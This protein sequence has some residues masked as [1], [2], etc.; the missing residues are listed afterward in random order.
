MY[1]LRFELAQTM[2]LPI[3]AR[4]HASSLYNEL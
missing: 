2:D 1:C 3:Y 4:F